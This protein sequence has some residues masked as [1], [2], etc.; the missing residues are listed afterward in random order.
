[1][2]SVF[3]VLVCFELDFIGLLVGNALYLKAIVVTS[4]LIDSIKSYALVIGF[5]VSFATLPISVV[6]V[7]YL[8]FHQTIHG[9]HVRGFTFNWRSLSFK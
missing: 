1:M 2:V 4:N 6:F 5:V 7:G 9:Q 3:T 8:A